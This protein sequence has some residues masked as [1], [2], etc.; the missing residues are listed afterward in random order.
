MPHLQ[1]LFLN[2]YSQPISQNIVK[3][4]HSAFMMALW[5]LKETNYP[6]PRKFQMRRAYPYPILVRVCVFSRIFAYLRVPTKIVV[7]RVT[8]P[9]LCRSPH[10]TTKIISL[11]LPLYTIVLRVFALRG[12]AKFALDIESHNSVTLLGRYKGRL[13][14][15]ELFLGTTFLEPRNGKNCTFCTTR[16]SRNLAIPIDT[17]KI[18]LQVIFI[19]I[20]RKLALLLLENCRFTKKY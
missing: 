17:V 1:A 4:L 11:V 18:T 13:T 10:H 8:K 15:L 12:R 5:A 6:S 2:V 16:K 19:D 20:W 7:V 9:F 3:Q 14:L